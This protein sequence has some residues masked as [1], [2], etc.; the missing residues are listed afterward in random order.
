MDKI[1]QS[2]DGLTAKYSKYVIETS[3]G[4]KQINGVYTEEKSII[5]IVYN[6]LSID[7]LVKKQLLPSIVLIDG[8]YYT[9]DIIKYQ[10]ELLA[11]DWPTIYQCYSG[12][13]INYIVD[14]VD[15]GGA[16]YSLE[17]INRTQTW[18]PIKGGMSSA[19]NI[20]GGG[21]LAG[22]TL[23]LVAKDKLSGILVGVTAAHLLDNS[24]YNSNNSNTCN[25]L[26]HYTSGGSEYEIGVFLRSGKNAQSF[27]NSANYDFAVCA[28]YSGT[29]NNES[30]KQI[31]LDI[32]YAPEFATTTEINNSVGLQVFSS[33]ARSGA[34]GNGFC[35]LVVQSVSTNNITIMRENTDCGIVASVGDSG[36]AIL[37]NF[38][39]TWKIIGIIN[40][41]VTLSIAS[42]PRI[43][44]L[45]DILA[46]QA[47]SGE[48]AKFINPSSIKINTFD[49]TFKPAVFQSNN[50]A[51]LYSSYIGLT[52]EVSNG[53]LTAIT[54]THSATNNVVVSGNSN[55]T[56]T[57]F[58]ESRYTPYSSFTGSNLYNVSKASYTPT[59][60]MVLNFNP[61]SAVTHFELHNNL[62]FKNLNLL[63]SLKTLNLTQ[64]SLKTFSLNS[65]TSSGLT[66]INLSQNSLSAFT[67]N[68]FI[69]SG[70][71]EFN[72]SN[73]NLTTESISSLLIELSGKTSWSLPAIINLTGQTPIAYLFQGTA[74][75]QAYQNLISSG[76]TVY[77]DTL[78]QPKTYYVSTVFGD[79]S[80]NGLTETTPW[81]TVAKVS[82]MFSAGTINPGDSVL[83]RRGDTFSSTTSV[84][85]VI[86]ID[87]GKFGGSAKNG[88]AAL[89]IR[90]GA[91]GTSTQKPLF[92]AYR[93]N[94]IFRLVNV[95]YYIIEN[96]SFA[97]SRTNSKVTSAYL[98]QGIILGQ[99]GVEPLYGIAG[100]TSDIGKGIANYCQINNCDFTN[101]AN[102]ITITGNYNR[103]SGCTISDLKPT[104]AQGSLSYQLADRDLFA[105]GIIVTGSYNLITRTNITGA[106]AASSLYGYWGAGIK[107][108]STCFQNIVNYCTISDSA[109]AI[110]LG[111]YNGTTAS[112]A[113]QQTRIVYNKIINNGN[114]TYIA[115]PNLS[116]SYVTPSLIN[117]VI[118]QNQNSRFSG[119]NYGNGISGFTSIW[120]AFQYSIFAPYWFTIEPIAGVRYNELVN[121]IMF[122]Y[123]NGQQ[124]YPPAGIGNIYARNNN[125]YKLQNGG[126]IGLTPNTSEITASTASI[127]ITNETNIDPLL[128]DYHLPAGSIARNVGLSSYAS[129]Y[130]VD[131][132]GGPVISPPSAGIYDPIT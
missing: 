57:Q 32:N 53:E 82:A 33:G 58:Y 127:L 44:V 78:P 89:P 130:P 59:S 111:V 65:F 113:N 104:P 75:Y 45:S 114:V 26:I 6:N 80:H 17:P 92:T 90:I 103:I 68:S 18:I 96:L 116:I 56:F 8:E 50:N 76:V 48:T 105:T 85:Y 40:S 52:T 25:K 125:I 110:E 21:Y 13:N 34:K 42:G 106:W 63:T 131:F 27:S 39:G 49:N 31:G 67:F 117:N 108:L 120:P 126:A 22:G 1:I 29:T 109:N 107:F 3:Y 118:V 81:K 55:F 15:Y 30:W 10:T 83:F 41:N 74:A 64:N 79:D 46:I 119:P 61:I 123:N 62:S 51:N 121:N 43:D 84:N 94:N 93:F 60:N 4:F 16:Q 112:Q 19:I 95:S 100:G 35:N 91:Y 72:L 128:W 102:A 54:L 129:I 86:D 36:S 9:T 88:T 47:W 28:L 66:K 97:A 12:W 11:C 101:L 124:I 7:E 73:N 77:V 23:G 132:D 70:L 38:S 2:L 20:F 14:N 98:R 99:Y 87:N 5:F 71:T 69:P 24:W 122:A 37:A 115:T